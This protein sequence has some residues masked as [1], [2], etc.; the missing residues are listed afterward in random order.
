[1]REQVFVRPDLIL[2]HLSIREE[3]KE[4]IHDVV[5]ECPAIVRVDCRPC[6]VIVEDVRQQG[7]C[8][9]RCFR[10]R[11]STGVLKRVRENGDE[12]GVVRR[13]RSEIGGVLFAGEEWSLI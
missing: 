1:L 11:I 3:R 7:P 13:L 2:R 8:D 12:T 4:E 5:G 10:C 6:G 9:P